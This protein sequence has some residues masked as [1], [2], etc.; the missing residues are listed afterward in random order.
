MS[1]DTITR[2]ADRVPVLGPEVWADLLRDA[3]AEE[4]QRAASYRLLLQAALR[5]LHD[6]QVAHGK[7]REQLMLARRETHRARGAEA[8]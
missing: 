2:I 5:L 3:L 7:T 4:R 6:E 8:A 1:I